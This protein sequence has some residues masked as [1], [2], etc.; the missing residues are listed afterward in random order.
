NTATTE[1]YTLSLHDALPICNRSARFP[2]VGDCGSTPPGAAA[3]GSAGA[4]APV[5]PLAPVHAAIALGK[6]FPLLP[7][8]PV[9]R[10]AGPKTAPQGHR[11]SQPVPRR[12]SGKQRQAPLLEEPHRKEAGAGVSS[13]AAIDR[14]P[15]RQAPRW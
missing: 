9:D 2:S 13:A 5:R 4:R 3:N 10:K 11:E 12:A 14:Q 8:M 7:S 15:P 6:G 1:H